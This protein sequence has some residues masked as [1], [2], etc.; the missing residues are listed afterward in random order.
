M[1]ECIQN[2]EVGHAGRLLELTRAP[3]RGDTTM[4]DSQGRYRLV[5]VWEGGKDLETREEIH[6]W[7]IATVAELLDRPEI[8]VF[9]F[10][11]DRIHL[12]L[13]AGRGADGS[14]FHRC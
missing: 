2:T 1:T 8:A 7:A 13:V 3:A 11:A 9:E 14:S 12:F 4:R 5:S 6:R 10:G